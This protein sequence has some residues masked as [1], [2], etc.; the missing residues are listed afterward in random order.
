MFRAFFLSVLAVAFAASLQATTPAV[1]HPGALPVLLGLDS[2]RKE[3]KV[4]SLQR[5]VLDSLRAEYKSEVRKLTNPMPTTPAQ[6]LA[7]ETQLGKLN[8]RY[9]ARALSVLNDSQRARLLEIEHQTLGATMLLSPSVQAKLALTAKQRQSIES[10]RRKGLD[11]VGKINRQFEE[12]RIGYHERIDLLRGR[13]LSQAE[14]FL[15]VLTPEQ[16]NAFLLIGG[17]KFAI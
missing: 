13:R 11:Y 17:D 1:D 7:A 5:A 14:A 12:G 3:L 15:K 4:G 10:I 16:R 8:E 2:V 6:R 9:N